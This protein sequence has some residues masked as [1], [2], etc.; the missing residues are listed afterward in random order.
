[1]STS[2]LTKEPMNSF[3]SKQ[4]IRESISAWYTQ[5]AMSKEF[6]MLTDKQKAE[7][8]SRYAELLRYFYE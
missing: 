3:A 7:Q 6:Q 2:E 5:Y 1:M 4:E 8:G